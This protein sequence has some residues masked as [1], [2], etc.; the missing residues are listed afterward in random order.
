MNTIN[1]KHHIEITVLTPLSIGAGAEKDW[2]KGLDFVV[3][4]D[5][6]YLLNMKKL[7]DNGINPAELTTFFTNKD[8]AGLLRKIE[9]KLDKV[10]DRVMRLP[11]EC[12]N[13]IKSFIINELSNNPIVPGSSIKGA[14]RSVILNYLL[15]GTKPNKFYEKDYFGSS[16]DGD[17]LMRFIK[18]SDAEFKETALINTKIFNLFH[19]GNSWQGGWKDSRNQTNNNFRSTGFNT[20]YECVLPNKKSVCIMMISDSD[21]FT[22]RIERYKQ[23]KEKLFDIKELF[24]IIN[25]HTV[26]YINKEIAFF[27][28]Y[29][30]SKTDR[31][32]ES[33]NII[34]DQSPID[35]SFCLLKM[36]AGSGFHSIT[37]D[38][39]YQDYVN[40][41][42]WEYGDRNK[43]HHPGAPK[44]KSRKIACQTEDVFSL[45]GFVKL[46][47]MSDEEVSQYEQ[48]LVRRKAEQRTERR[49]I[50]EEI[51]KA[52]KEKARIETERLA[53]EMIKQERI[54]KEKLEKEAAE[55]AEKERLAKLSPDDRE[56]EKYQHGC[57]GELI[58]AS[59]GNSE[60]TKDF[61]QWLKEKLISEKLWKPN[62]DPKKDKTVKRCQAIKQKLEL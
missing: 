13:D 3:K 60:L 27:E 39:Q 1:N 10:S 24:K 48:D 36:S 40:T 37:G 42:K 47:I 59:I 19:N 51:L 7:V 35:N 53:L 11:A 25:K 28:S 30:A 52:E 44:Y 26:D 49:K 2:V 17:E 34:K 5:E 56:K 55:K 4:G 32:I 8:S 12:D 45:M 9:S 57:S 33:L 22:Q 29:A 41:G 20:L 21:L 61:F 31:I 16:K 50:A 46:R 18:F 23:N 38:W 58:N 15:K 43:T 6:I 54:A 62:G 14:V